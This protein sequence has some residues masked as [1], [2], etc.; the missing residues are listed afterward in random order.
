MARAAT[1]PGAIGYV[2]LDV[3]NDSVQVIAIDGIKPTPEAIQ[4]GSY[5]LQ[6]PFVM[7]TD[8]E[9]SVQSEIVQEFFVYLKSQ[10]GRSLIRSVGLI[11]V[12]DG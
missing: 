12:N 1:I 2:S 11:P 3:L 9:L 4:S 7:V 8:G 10:E 5:L 6:R